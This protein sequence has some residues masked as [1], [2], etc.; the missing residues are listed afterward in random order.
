MLEQHN[1]SAT[2]HSQSQHSLS[3]SEFTSGF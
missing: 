1:Q 3:V 2:C